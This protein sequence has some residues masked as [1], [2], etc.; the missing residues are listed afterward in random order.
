MEDH[1]LDEPDQIFIIDGI[2]TLGVQMLL[3]ERSEYISLGLETDLSICFKRMKKNLKNPE[4]AEM[5]FCD[6]EALRQTRSELEIDACLA[7]ATLL[8]EVN[9]FDTGQL[10]FLYDKI[11]VAL[12]SIQFIKPDGEDPEES[13]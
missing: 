8:L 10:G 3:E 1:A 4:E 12:Q 13:G 11:D 9:G 5:S 2:R 7:R 6:Y